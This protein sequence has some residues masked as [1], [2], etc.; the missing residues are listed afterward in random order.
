[1]KTGKKAFLLAGAALL[2]TL[3]LPRLK[4][5]RQPSLEGLE[6]AEVTRAYDRISRM[7]QFA[8]MH[9]LTAS[10]LARLQPAGTLVD[11]GCG[12]GL[13]TGLIARRFPNLQ[14]TGL[15]TS[16]EMV[17]QANLNAAAQGFTP[18]RLQFHQGDVKAL[19]EAGAAFNFAVS[20]LSLHHWSERRPAGSV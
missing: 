3:G 20:S 10:Y 8:A 9:A 6:D 15:D 16:L 17:Q 7:P 18:P 5:P 11:I 19:E 14:V 4:L 2:T 13:L 1:M 12:P